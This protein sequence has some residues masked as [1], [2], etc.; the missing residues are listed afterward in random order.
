[1]EP[2][3][4]RPPVLVAPPRRAT[5]ERSRGEPRRLTVLEPAD[6]ATYRRLVAH[7]APAVERALMPAVIANRVVG[8]GLR[9]EDHRHARA[10]WR[11]AVS[12]PPGG[13]RVHLDVAD[14]YGSIAPPVVVASLRSTGAAVPA[15]LISLLHELV[16]HGVP[17]LAVGP[18]PSAVL[19][20]AVLHDV[21]RALARAGAEH[22][23][24]VDDLV[25]HVGSTREAT[26][27]IDVVR[28]TLEPL[29]LRLQDAKTRIADERD[30]RRSLRRGSAVAGERVR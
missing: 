18:E 6:A 28:R 1:M 24:W 3:A 9:L 20:N 8:P 21:D 29:G 5:L 4:R 30:G 27:A 16:A 25:I 17:G 12:A 26:R 22:Q 14:Y 7:V 10:R 15:E 19:A 13:I 23:R 2:L 11:H